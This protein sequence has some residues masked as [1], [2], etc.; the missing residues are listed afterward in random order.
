MQNAQEKHFLKGINRY[1]NS[2]YNPIIPR[3]QIQKMWLLRL[4][5]KWKKR[6]DDRFHP[7]KL[8]ALY[9]SGC[10]SFTVLNNGT[11]ME[12]A[13]IELNF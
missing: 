13:F 6:S 5:E 3:S 9:L 12:D 7:P 8:K 1:H 10:T 4:A 2:K 11:H